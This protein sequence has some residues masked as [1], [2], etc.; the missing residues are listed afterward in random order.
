MFLKKTC[1]EATRDAIEARPQNEIGYLCKP[2]FL[3]QQG[4]MEN[5]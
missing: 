5:L 1:L 2:E 4:F 3:V